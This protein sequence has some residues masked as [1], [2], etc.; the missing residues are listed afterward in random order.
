MLT[1]IMLHA[2]TVTAGVFLVL[3]DCIS[4]KQNLRSMGE[5]LRNKAAIGLSQAVRRTP[6][7]TENRS[8]MK[9]VISTF[10]TCISVFLSVT[11]FLASLGAGFGAGFSISLVGIL[12]TL[13]FQWLNRWQSYTLFKEWIQE[14]RSQ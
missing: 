14:K 10:F 2:L 9:V 4:I 5:I 13:F 11:L 3:P 6:K 12:I 8:F 1:M 7:R